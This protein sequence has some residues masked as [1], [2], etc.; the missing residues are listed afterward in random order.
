MVTSASP[1]EGK[2][3]TAAHLAI[4]HAHQ[5]LRT[6]L[7]E[8]DL[9]RPGMRII[10]GL[11]NG[12][13]LSHVLSGEY[14]WREQIVRREGVPGLDILPAGAASRRDADLI[15]RAIPRILRE[16]TQRAGQLVPEYH[17]GSISLVS[18]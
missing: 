17:F 6:L 5:K 8:C 12:T 4:S 2:T 16:A 18:S 3:T 9:R 10:F 13:G 1:A 11:E 15:G 14:P 7:I